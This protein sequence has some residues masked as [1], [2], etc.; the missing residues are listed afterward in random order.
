[1]LR[2]G[3]QNQ[4]ADLHAKLLSMGGRIEKMMLLALDALRNGNEE[5]A[6]EV[7]QMEYVIDAMAAEVDALAIELIAK[8]QPV[9]Q[10]LRRIIGAMRLSTDMERVA[11]ISVNIVEQSR[12]LPRPLIK[13]LVDI[14]RMVDVAASMVQDALNAL[15]NS[16][17]DLALDVWK[18]DDIVDEL[19][20]RIVVELRG[21]MTLDGS[22]VPKALPLLIIA[23]QIERIADHATNLAESV[24]FIAT[25]KKV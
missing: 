14:P 16:D 21:M 19:C 25:G 3:F 6:Q 9:G 4:L 1:M 12:L 22:V 23:I 13:P 10:D 2:Q 24:M 7:E 15:I 5:A 20:D 8:Q 11:D 17:V 18:R